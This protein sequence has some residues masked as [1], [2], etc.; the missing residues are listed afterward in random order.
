M[1]KNIAPKRFLY[2][3]FLISAFIGITLFNLT[4]ADKLFSGIQEQLSNSLGWLIILA[5]NAILVFVIYLAFSKHKNLILGG[6]DAKPEFSNINW[7]AMLFSAG[8][9]IGL[10]FYGVAE[11]IM[12]LSSDAIHQEGATFSDQ[13][14]LSMNLTYL[15]WG[16]HGWAIYGVVGLCFAYFS[17]NKNLPFRVSSFFSGTLTQNAW[18]RVPLDIIAIIATIFGIAT[19]LGLG[20]NQINS[21]LGYM[22]VLEESFLTTVWIIAFITLLGLISVVLGLQTGIKRLSQLNMILCGLM[23]SIVFIAGPTSFI[24]D[25]L[26]QNVGSYIQNLL[27][28]STNT[29]AYMDSSWQNGWTLFYYSWWFAWSPFV[30]LFIARISYG[31]SIQEFLLGVVVI[32]SILVFVWMGIFGNAALHQELLEP[33]SLSTAINNDITISLFVFLEQFPY[34][35]ILMGLSIVIILTF[36]V[37]SSDS[38]AL[39]TSMLTAANNEKAQDEPPMLLR[40]VWAISLG[41]IAVVLLAGGGLGALQTS[42]IVTG[43][44]FAILIFFACK[45]LLKSLNQ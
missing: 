40:V 36:F 3:L 34:S 9:G 8:L 42:V 20:A 25:G 24:V 2:S 1:F 29:Q 5:A 28:L 41:I 17:F 35:P 18:G 26:L 6:P 44:P 32:P 13:A 21:G 22:G 23:L 43:V 15:H 45:S 37:T 16:F 11:P 10:L 30:G 31:R 19:S 4:E 38:G 7:I 27:A 14:N 12:H 39:V 33:N